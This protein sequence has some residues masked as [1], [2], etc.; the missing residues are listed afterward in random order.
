MSNKQNSKPW[1]WVGALVL[2]GVGVFAYGSGPGH[3]FADDGT[4]AIAGAPVRRG[5]LAIRVVERGS[6]KAADFVS[7]KNE[8][9]GSSTILSLVKEGVIVKE[10][11]L[12]CE[13][14]ATNQIERRVTQEI[15][16][17]NADAAFVKSTQNYAIQQSQNESDVAQAQQKLAFAEQDLR[18]Y[19]E[20]D[21]MLSLS[22]AEQEITLQEEEYKR[23]ANKLDWSEKLSQRGFL[24]ATELEADRLSKNRSGVLLDQA[25]A[26]QKLL[27]DFQVQRDTDKL[28][29][30]LKEARR[31]LDR[32]QLQAKARL[33]D[34][35]SDK[36]TNE[37]KLK[38]EKEKLNK[39]DNQIAKAKIYAPKAGM[40]V[41][42]KQD[43]GGRGMGQSQP[44][45]EGTQVRERQELITIPTAGG[46]LGT[47]SLHESVLKQI[48]PGQ[49]CDVRVDA[50]A[51]KQ[52]HGT[53][54]N[55]AVLPDQNSW[56]A[57]PNTR[58]YTTMVE[59]VDG[60]EEMRPGMSCSVEIRVEDIADAIYIPVQAVFRHLG[61]NIA[62]VDAGAGKYDVATVKTDR[63]NDSHV[64]IT[65]GLKEGQIVL[66]SAPLA[67][68]LQPGETATE[69]T[70]PPG[71]ASP[72]KPPMTADDGAPGGAPGGDA[73]AEGRMPRP[74]RGGEN[75]GG[76]P[77]GRN[78]GGGRGQRGQ[79]RRGGGAP[80]GG[81][82]GA[83][84]PD[85]PAGGEKPKDAA[86]E[87][88]SDK[89]EP[90]KPGGH[91]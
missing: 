3:W 70:V 29:A 69:Q 17:R 54:K 81:D 11:D 63:F 32:V 31:E 38:I 44:I 23:A 60:V 73:G 8:L 46:M 82:G 14:D 64:Q 55:V 53:V 2:V 66:L 13:L 15:A 56:F 42:A 34:F 27:L 62:F 77:G 85:D 21:K 47:V 19:L 43:E 26:E 68:H 79:G 51:P 1:I 35:E 36:L 50:L 48:K 59:I 7:I 57:N 28:Q 89:Q 87:S 71:G 45:Q 52:F 91:R 16:V 25:K 74:D 5:P 78:F 30:D 22:K 9:E 80:G 88:A 39:L 61:K 6:L 12:I 4:V 40:V 86:T 90:V 76:N 49:L 72:L 65:E 84:K 67:F 10:G 18:K 37:A 58:L 41:Y 83:P 20:G 75:A 24:T 33:V